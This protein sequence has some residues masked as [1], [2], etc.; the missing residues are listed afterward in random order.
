MS[1][2]S[3][4]VESSHWSVAVLVNNAIIKPVGVGQ[5]VCSGQQL[6]Q[7]GVEVDVILAPGIQPPES[8]KVAFCSFPHVYH[9]IHG[10]SLLI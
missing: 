2:V 10:T 7:N 9:P 4:K 6:P 1:G 5:S 3:C 8:P